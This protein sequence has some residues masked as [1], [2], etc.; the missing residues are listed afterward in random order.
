MPLSDREKN[1][2]QYEFLKPGSDNFTYFTAL[3][4]GYTK[5]LNFT[6]QDLDRLQTIANDREYILSK[7]LEKFEYEKRQQQSKLKKVDNDKEK[8]VNIDWNDFELVETIVFDDDN[9]IRDSTSIRDELRDM[10]RRRGG[11]ESNPEKP[12]E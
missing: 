7:C 1:N 6:A 11:Y 12:I 5:I 10:L 8:E 9:L 3:V 2:P 4:D